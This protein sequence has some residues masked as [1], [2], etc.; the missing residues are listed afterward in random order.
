MAIIERTYTIPIRHEWLKAPRYKRA[1]R[2]VSAIRS[3][4]TAHMHSEDI[5]LGT[6][7]NL[8]IWKHGMKNPPSCV[9]VTVM[10]DEE[11][12]VRAEL[13][14]APKMEAKKDA[15]KKNIAQKVAEA[16]TGTR[17]E[18]KKT[19]VKEAP[20]PAPAAKPADAKPAAA[21]PAAQPAAAKKA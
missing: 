19:V 11:G 9:K 8:F 2:S 7:L 14:G 1:K 3:F 16:V 15:P 20:K 10:K 21:K 4:L 12:V 13:I 5:R 17:S 6:H 18:P